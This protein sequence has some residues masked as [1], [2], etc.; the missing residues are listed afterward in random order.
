MVYLDW[1]S[2]APPDDE[3]MAEALRQ[4]RDAFANPSSQ[5]AAGRLAREHLESSRAALASVLGCSAAEVV[6]TS[7]ASES[8][9]L[10]LSSVLTRVRPE[11]AGGRAPSV[12]A[13]AIEHPSIHDNLEALRGF[14]VRVLLVPARRS[15]AVA[16]ADVLERME[17]QT[18]MVILM[19][20]NNVTG[21]LQPVSDVSAAVARYSAEHGRR[22]IVHTDAVQALGKVPLDLS[23]LGADTAS[24]SA[25]KIGGPRGVGALYVRS[26][27]PLEPLARGGEQE[28]GLRAG[29]ENVV[30][31]AAFACAAR[32]R[33]ASLARDASHAGAL[34][35]LIR[36]SL[37]D[38]P[39]CAFL[40]LDR[41]GPPEGCGFSP[42][43]VSAA[44]P[45]I[46]SEVLVRV[47]SSQ[48]IFVSSGS[49]CASRNKE[50]R[51]RVYRGMGVP[52][53]LASSALRVS[54][55]P[56][57]TEDDVLRLAEALRREVPRLARVAG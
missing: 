40:P 36:E 29:T 15:G 14:G 13:T 47:L 1:A 42:Y 3:C 22:V 44:F 31:A 48:G 37:A 23:T 27:T 49:A 57:T 19:T 53:T 2:T 33:H 38:V 46:P 34:A 45:P 30:G 12:V 32:K 20:V 50:K 43:I 51:E 21:A 18:V 41:W 17:P 24:F 25:H 16:V 39:G 52:P 54:I 35:T 4:N 9:W 5:H 7:G 56:D 10:V 8:N 28:R 11:A 6:L 55:G 26:G